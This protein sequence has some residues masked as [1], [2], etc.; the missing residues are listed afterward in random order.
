MGVHGHA[1]RA[2]PS[3]ESSNVVRSGP[4]DRRGLA[5]L[6]APSACDLPA[7]LWAFTA[8]QAEHLLR[9]RVRT[10]SDQDHLIGA[11]SQ[12]CSPRRPAIFPLRYGRSRP[13]RPSTSF[14]SE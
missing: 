9:L 13:R 3:A 8:T 6:L 5:G 7:P 2:P 11:D 1:G 4:L 10:L 14:G 12:A